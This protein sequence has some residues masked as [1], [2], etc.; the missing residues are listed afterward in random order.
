MRH[1]LSRGG[2]RKINRVLHIMAVVQ[3]RNATERRAYYD[4][5]VATGKTP[6]EAR[7]CLKRC[8][9]DLVYRALLDDLSQGVATGPGGH[10]GNG[11][12]SSA[13]GSQPDTGSSDKSLPGPAN[14]QPTTGIPIAS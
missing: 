8:L 7:R 9:S 5:K 14:T 6:Y 10:S 4:H 1:R 11:S 13:T 2:N 12:D 3:L